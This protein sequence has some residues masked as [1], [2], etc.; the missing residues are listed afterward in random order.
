[1]SYRINFDESQND[2]LLSFC[3]IYC[4]TR[5]RTKTLL[6]LSIRLRVPFILNTTN[7]V[8]EENKFYVSHAI[9]LIPHQ[10]VV[11]GI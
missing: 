2:Y 5:F 4:F 1:M 9:V 6:F 10:V 8:W 3:V 7:R 11:L